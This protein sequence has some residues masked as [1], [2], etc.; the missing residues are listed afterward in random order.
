MQLPLLCLS[1]QLQLLGR[2]CCRC[3]LVKWAHNARL[4]L[5][6]LLWGRWL[7]LQPAAI[8]PPRAEAGYSSRWG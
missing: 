4:L 8:R 1:R 6:L 7:L 5:L 2:M 3:H